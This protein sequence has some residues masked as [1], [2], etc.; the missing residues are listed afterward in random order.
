M[1]TLDELDPPA[2]GEPPVNTFLVLRVHELRRMPVEEFDV[3]ALR[4]LIG[5]QIAL[6]VLMPRALGVLDADPLA[7]GDFYPGDLLR[8]VLEVDREYWAAHPEQHATA[9]AIA[10]K[11]R[12]DDVH[13]LDAVATFLGR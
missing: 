13:V 3:E 5:Q 7:A 11:T 12:T 2:W 4:L 9:T 1:P 10:T 6:P 8:S